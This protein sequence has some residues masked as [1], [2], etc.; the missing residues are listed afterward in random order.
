MATYLWVDYVRTLVANPKAVY[1]IV[2]SG[3]FYD[4]LVNSEL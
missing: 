1:G 3:I 4:P 2:D